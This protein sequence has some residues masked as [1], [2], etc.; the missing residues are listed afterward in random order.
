MTT[1]RLA[2]PVITLTVGPDGQPFSVPKE[3]LIENP[4]FSQCL[5][6]DR[7]QEGTNN[8]INLPEDDP[9]LMVYILRFLH[10]RR[11]DAANF[12]GEGYLP[13]ERQIARLIKLH[14]LADKYLIKKL[15]S[16]ITESIQPHIA[17]QVIPTWNDLEKL[18]DLGLQDTMLWHEYLQAIVDWA[19]AYPNNG[20]LRQLLSDGLD[21]DAEAAA[22]ILYK[23]EAA[24]HRRDPFCTDCLRP[25][26][27]CVCVD[28]YGR[29]KRERRSALSQIRKFFSGRHQVM[30]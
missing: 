2:S 19:V 5:E 30:S 27:K 9:E 14:A 26:S 20:I 8:L 21:K 4:F 25:E 29:L 3:I 24:I 17:H 16:E 13:L 18:N 28:I 6:N 10:T 7:Y 15:C 12:R 1:R 11:F 23:I 22:G